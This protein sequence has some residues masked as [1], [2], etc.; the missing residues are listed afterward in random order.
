M[1]SLL[2]CPSTSI[3]YPH[4]ACFTKMADRNLYFVKPQ[5][6]QQATDMLLPFPPSNKD[7]T[8]GYPFT[9][10]SFLI[11]FVC[12]KL[13]FMFHCIC[14]ITVSIFLWCTQSLESIVNGAFVFLQTTCPIIY[15]FV[16][17][18]IPTKVYTVTLVICYKFSM[19][20]W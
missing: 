14:S 3:L 16:Y 20:D 7:F 12:E 13:V 11:H 5:E 19:A 6:L 4:T 18:I 9:C 2:I 17:T 8:Y 15:F 1:D 10:F